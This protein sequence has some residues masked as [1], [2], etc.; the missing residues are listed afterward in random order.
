MGSYID[1][2]KDVLEE[3]LPGVTLLEL[4]GKMSAKQ[5]KI[6]LNSFKSDPGPIIF[7]VSLRAGGVGINL[8]SSSKSFMLDL[9]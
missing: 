9:W 4:R 1:I 2:M 7:L 6:T 5:R 8:T 3:E